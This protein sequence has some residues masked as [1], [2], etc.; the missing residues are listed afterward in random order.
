MAVHCNHGKG[1]TGT[2]IIAFLIYTGFFNKFT[3]ALEFYNKRRFISKTYGV[4][5]PC[6]KRYLE[7][8]QYLKEDSSIQP[9]LIAY[10]IKDLKQVGLEVGKCY[11]SVTRLRNN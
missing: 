6:Q 11:I 10:Q 4:S 3:D 1:R 8:F 2:T 5:Q 7:Y 9:K